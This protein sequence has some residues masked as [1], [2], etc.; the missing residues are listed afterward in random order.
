MTSEESIT[1]FYSWQSDRPRTLNQDFIRDALNSAAAEM[2]AP[3]RGGLPI[4]IDEATRNRPG[5]PNIPGSILE[6]I[7][8]ADVFVCDVTLINSDPNPRFRVPNPNVLVELGYAVAVLGWARIVM[9]FN[10]AFGMIE[11]LPFDI[12]QHRVTP[13]TLAA[14]IEGGRSKKQTQAGAQKFGLTLAAAIET[15]SRSNPK[16]PHEESSVAQ[17]LTAPVPDVRVTVNAGYQE[18]DVRPITFALFIEVQ[19]HSPIPIYI[20]AVYLQT[21]DPANI[22]VP[23]GDYVSGEYLRALELQP[24]RSFSLSVDPNAI[25]EYWRDDR[26]LCVVAKDGI[27]RLYRSSESE[28][29]RAL[30]ILF[31]QYLRRDR[32]SK[33]E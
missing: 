32:S 6:K 4:Y 31:I 17:T 25:E 33:T 18:S 9:V 1:V 23:N 13:Y 10:K 26:L 8:D 14:S 11:D 15:I 28:L 12:R 20:N 16:R 27:G 19:N 22:I 30:Q 29:E 24:G 5:S 3:E 2:H 21:R 7:R